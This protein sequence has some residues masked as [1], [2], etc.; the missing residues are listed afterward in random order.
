MSRQSPAATTYPGF[1]ENLRRARLARRLSVRALGAAVGVT[2][3]AINYYE[4]GRSYPSSSVLVSLARALGVGVECLMSV[5]VCI[6]APRPRQKPPA[7]RLGRALR[8]AALW[9]QSARRWRQ[10]AQSRAVREQRALAALRALVAAVDDAI[11]TNA[12]AVDA[13]VISARVL[14]EEAGDA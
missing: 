3:Q 11:C 8:W 12:D 10:W 5:E 6:A 14:L 4:R 1:P 2:G 13:A 9:R 7:T